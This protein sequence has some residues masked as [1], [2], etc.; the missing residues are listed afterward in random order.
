MIPGGYIIFDDYKPTV[1]KY[2]GPKKAIDDF[3]KDKPEI[4]AFFKEAN[5]PVCYVNKI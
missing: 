2:T 4:L 1:A 5:H 3:F